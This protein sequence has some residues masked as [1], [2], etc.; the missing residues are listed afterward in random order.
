MD[1]QY[2]QQYPPQPS[3]QY[4]QQAAQPVQQNQYD[5][6]QYYG[7]QANPPGQQPQPS[8]GM[9]RGLLVGVVVLMLI[10][11]GVYFLGPSLAGTE[12]GAGEGADAGMGEATGGGG[13]AGGEVTGTWDRK[14]PCGLITKEDFETV[15]DTTVSEV[16][17]DT[18]TDTWSCM[19]MTTEGK[20]L[21]VLIFNEQRDLEGIGESG[22]DVEKHSI[23]GIDTY[24]TTAFNAV[25]SFNKE[26]FSISIDVTILNAADGEELDK[27]KVLAERAIRR[28]S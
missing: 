23:L 6:S 5:A 17:S 18:E 10:I 22:G 20:L 9:G 4:G 14:D 1:N 3:Q 16:K 11:G 19:Y 13:S 28:M 27:S 26:P 21:I 25:L 2:N 8:S 24:W 15:L 7:P 12:P